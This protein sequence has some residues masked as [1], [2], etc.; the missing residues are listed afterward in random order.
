MKDS[1]VD[2]SAWLQTIEAA[3]FVI[4]LDEAKPRNSAERGQQFLHANGFNRWA[5]KSVQF[6]VCDNGVS[7]TIGEHAMLDGVVIRRLNDHITA[8]IM[9]L[10]PETKPITDGSS[11]SDDLSPLSMVDGYAFQTTTLLN[12]HIQRVRS[13]VQKYTS[14]YEFAAFEVT[15]ASTSFFRRYKCPPKSSMVMAIQLAVRRH[16]GFTPGSF[17]SV[18]LSHFL[19]GRVELNHVAWPEVAEF[20]SAAADESPATTGPSSQS[21]DLRNLFFE[22]MRTHAKNVFRASSGHGIDRHLQCLQWSI[23]DGEQVPSL[24]TNP[25]YPKSRNSNVTNVMT[26]SLATGVL[27]CGA[28]QPEPNSFWIHF[29]PEENR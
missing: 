17:E 12:Q 19:R 24:F 4:Y 2:N 9:D 1:S 8:A 20:C 29:E 22:G 3:A 10:Q 21:S 16:Y 18:S 26:D 5:D 11:S 13:Q 23:Q 14:R 28:I 6:V 15:T 27:E 7:A 25:L